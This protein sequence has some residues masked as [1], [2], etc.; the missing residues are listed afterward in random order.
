MKIFLIDG[1]RATW[2]GNENGF[3]INLDKISS[4][5]VYLTF[6]QLTTEVIIV[7]PRSCKRKETLFIS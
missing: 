7:H 1:N 3:E 2:N 4:I 6:L 5:F